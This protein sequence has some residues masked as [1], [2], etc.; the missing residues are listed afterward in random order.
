MQETM[1]PKQKPTIINSYCR[2]S[3]QIIPIKD[4]FKTHTV[5]DNTSISNFYEKKTS[6]KKPKQHK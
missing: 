4:P 1:P 5:D 2:I 6:K 3:K